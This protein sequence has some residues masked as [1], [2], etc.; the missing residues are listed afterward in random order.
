LFDAV[1]HNLVTDTIRAV[2]M[3]ARDLPDYAGRL[4]DAYERNPELRRMAT[5][6]RLERAAPHPQLDLLVEN[7]RADIAAIAQSQKDG[8]IPVRFAAV[9]ILT[10]VLSIAAMWM[11]QTPELTGVIQRLSRARRRAVVVD[12]VNAILA[13]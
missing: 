10:I 2:P 3:D 9:E 8:R 5:W 13:F 11:S 1:F 7:N 12:A 4:F 6:R